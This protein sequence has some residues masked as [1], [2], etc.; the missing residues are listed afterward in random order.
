MMCRR[1]FQAAGPVQ[2]GGLVQMRRDRLEGGQVQQEVE[3]DGPPDGGRHDAEHRVPLVGQPADLRC[4]P[5]GGEQLVGE[6]EVGREDHVQEQQADDAGGQQE[7][8]EPA[9]PPQPLHH[10]QLVG[11][12]GQHEADDD[13]GDGGQDREPDGVPQRGPDVRVAHGLG[14][15]V[16]ADE[17]PAGAGDVLAGQAHSQTGHEGPDQE[18]GV[19][20]EE[21]RD[22]DQ[23][24]LGPLPAHASDGT[25][26]RPPAGLR[27]GSPAPP[28][29]WRS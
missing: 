1:R 5:D 27:H 7:R 23:T 19:H 4:Q 13:E 21:G 17:L 2:F 24:V 26:G 28:W 8:R 25:P 18:E 22:E 20:D 29:W 11:E 10:A 9:E 6:A 12:Q 15:V 16:E 3:A 14:V